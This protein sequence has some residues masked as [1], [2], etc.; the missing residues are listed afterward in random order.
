MFL[1]QERWVARLEDFT[2]NARARALALDCSGFE[3]RRPW[4]KG[5]P[6][7]QRRVAILSTAALGLR[8]DPAYARES[9]E[10]RVIPGDT[11][12]GELVIGHP[13]VNFDRTGFQQDFNICFPLDRLKE[14]AAA[15][16]IGSV[17]DY[18]YAVSGANNPHHLEG[19]ARAMAGH[20]T[21]D[22]VD[23]VLLLP[24]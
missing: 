15:G 11:A 18:H 4:V 22:G 20:M 1:R 3:G 12:P 16:V 24:V 2:D 14:L 10:Y 8:G 5:P 13:S 21:A 7:N 9:P 17:A 23:T 19:S 6:L